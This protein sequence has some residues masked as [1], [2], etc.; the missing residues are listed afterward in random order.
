MAKERL[1]RLHGQGGSAIAVVVYGNRAYDD[2]LLELKDIL[3]EAGY[4]VPSA[5]AFIAEHSIIRSIAE[6]RPTVEDLQKAE[7][8]GQ[9]AVK[10]INNHPKSI[11]VPG[12]VK[13]REKA[14]G[15]AR[16][17]KADKK[18]ISCGKCAALCP[19][20]A[21]PVNQP[22][23]TDNNLCIGCMRCVSICPEKARALP[24][25]A[26]MAVQTFLEQSASNE[27]QPEIFL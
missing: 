23:M 4:Q 1:S 7:Q 27:K 15:S 12:D 13:Y 22:D 25:E 21:I 16:N 14:P 5:A 10:K 11:S 9:E 20:H 6:G 8:F 18:C 19:V 26:R 17:P 2:A 3:E 24:D